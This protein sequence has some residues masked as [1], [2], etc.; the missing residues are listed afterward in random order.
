M[1]QVQQG[2]KYGQKNIN[3]IGG[4]RTVHN[5]FIPKDE[6]NRRLK[7]LHCIDKLDLELNLI[8]REFITMQTMKHLEEHNY[9]ADEQNGGRGENI[10]RCSIA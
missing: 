6:H 8:R 5:I 1:Q 9:L 4:Q 7:Q 2:C 3:I 10:H